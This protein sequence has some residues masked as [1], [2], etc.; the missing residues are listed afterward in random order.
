MWRPL[1][2]IQLAIHLSCPTLP[3]SLTESYARILREQAGTRHFDPI[4]VVAIV[5]NESHWHASVVDGSGCV[6]LGQICL[7]NYP[8]CREDPQGKL[9]AAQKR[10][11][12]DGGYN[13]I[14]IAQ[15]ITQWRKYCRR[16][17]GK[18]A[19]LRRWLYGYQ[20]HA[21]RDPSRQCG[22]R[23]TRHGWVDLPKPALVKKIL[24]R[25]AELA[26]AAERRL[27]SSHKRR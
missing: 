27:H 12:L 19:L 22:M 2:L 1:A 18:P 20:G 24:R 15:E 6:G 3:A 14:T 7:S 25:R 17:T 4:T 10:L 11:L 13:L 16:L 9:C 23:K 5:E 8:T 26:R 21:S